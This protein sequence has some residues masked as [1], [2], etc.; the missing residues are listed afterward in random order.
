MAGP[1]VKNHDLDRL[2][3]LLQSDPE[4]AKKLLKNVTS[5]VLIPHSEGQKEVLTAQERFLVLCAGR[6]WGKSKIGAARALR[7]ARGDRPKKV[8]WV[9]PLYKIVKRGYEA[10]VDQIPEGQLSK[11]APSSAGF[12]AGRAIKLEF[13]NGSTIEFFTAQN[14]E[15]MLGASFDY[16]IM[17][18]A[19][20]LKEHVWTQI[21]R[22]T[23]ADRQGG[24]LFIS[25]PRGKNW[26]Y[27]LWNRGQ[28]Q[29]DNDKIYR[30]WRFQS[31]TN[32]TIPSEEFTA[33]AD[34]LPLAE[35]EQEILALFVSQAAAVFR[36]NWEKVPN[37][38]NGDDPDDYG[39]NLSLVNELGKPDGHVV[40]GIDLAK[41]HD[42]TVIL[43]VRS[44]DRV[45]CYH[46]RFNKISWPDQRRAIHTAVQDIMQSATGITILMDSTGVGDVVYDDLSE[47][48]LDI[49]PVKFTPQWKQDAIR[50]LSADLER[51]QAFVIEEQLDEF[52]A[53][54][55][56][57]SDTGRMK[58]EASIGHDDEVSA[59]L[60][61][62]W[63]IVHSGVPNIQTL[64]VG[65]DAS[66]DPQDNGYN[67]QAY[68]EGRRQDTGLP[69]QHE[70]YREPTTADLMSNPNLWR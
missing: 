14:A 40:I 10:V 47:E 2:I 36:F 69:Q 50:L 23:L 24:A 67:W 53:Y 27:K 9:A 68:D 17:D 63:G 44:G 46:D 48:G 3:S 42:F 20:T 37:P 30:S 59:A 62:H 12:D 33:M 25:T 7:E 11:P 32:P 70:G 52:E 29:D 56:S 49:V 22:P 21:I 38:E 35:Y 57:M 60:L 45:P 54:A 1:N 66:Y 51:G 39:R 26:F 19:A 4:G 13:K 16:L 43:G 64:L 8:L 41:H 5:K 28:S 61:A 18:E 55:S 15:G 34:E 65:G 6:R 58:Y 31:Y